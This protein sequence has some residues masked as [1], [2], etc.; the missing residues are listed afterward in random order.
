LQTPYGLTEPYFPLQGGLQGDSMGVDAYLLV[1][2]A[3]SQALR[4]RLLGLEHPVLKGEFIPEIIF[5]DDGR[6]FSLSAEGLGATLDESAELAN[7][8]GASV[9]ISKLK[10]YCIELKGGSLRYG[11]HTVPCSLGAL[12]TDLSCLRMVGIPCVMGEDVLPILKPIEK[13]MHRLLAKVRHHRPSCILALRLLLSYEIASLDYRLSVVP[14]SGLSLRRLQILVHQVARSTI[15]VPCWFP[16]G[17]LVSPL[18]VGGLH[19]P[20]LDQRLRIRRILAS[21][22]TA[23]CRSV[24]AREIVKGLISDPIWNEY[25]WS[26]PFHLRAALTALD[27]SIVIDPKDRLPSVSIHGSWS[28]SPTASHIVAV[29]DGSADDFRVGFSTVFVENGIVIGTFWGRGL[30]WLTHLRG[31]PSGSAGCLPHTV[32]PSSK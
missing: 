19:F 29:S 1:H 12:E 13:A 23:C 6:L 17:V 10:V 24:Y 2:M 32:H 14:V 27:L 30:S 7:L 18:R 4:A 21:L 26:D 15:D 5:S 9:N 16:S 8:A 3:R 11:K 31:R 22:L 20:V 28:Q 25:A